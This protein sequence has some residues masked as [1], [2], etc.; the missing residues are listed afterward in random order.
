MNKRQYEYVSQIKQVPQKPH[1]A[2]L[3]DRSFSYDAG[4]G[5]GVSSTHQQVEYLAFADE[6]ALNAW[7]LDEAKG[8]FRTKN[9][10]VIYVN[11]VNVELKTTVSIVKS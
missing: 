10:C 11:P 3:I 1:F 4:Y 9:Y 8:Q 7:I 5:D 2:V 6:D